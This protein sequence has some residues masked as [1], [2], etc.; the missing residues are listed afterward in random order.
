M[1][2]QITFPVFVY[3]GFVYK[4]VLFSFSLWPRQLSRILLAVWHPVS[5]H[6]E[7][8]EGTAVG[9]KGPTAFHGGLAQGGNLGKDKRTHNRIQRHPHHI[10]L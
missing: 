2:P 4:S 7:W 6:A 1:W 9:H 5:S 3:G 8:Y 10:S